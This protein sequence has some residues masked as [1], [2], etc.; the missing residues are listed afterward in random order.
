M[1]RSVRLLFCLLALGFAGRALAS[2]VHTDFDVKPMPLRTPPPQYPAEM[3]SKGVAGIVLLSIVIDQQGSVESLDVVR[4]SD[5][6]FI[7]ATT[8]AVKQW[9]FKPAQKGGQTVRAKF[10][11]PVQFS[12]D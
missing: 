11:L 8:A 9:R 1:K 6:A 2:E 5:D 7:P 10:Q 12:A 4:A 3:K